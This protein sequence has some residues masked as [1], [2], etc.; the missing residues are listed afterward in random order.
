MLK[1]NERNKSSQQQDANSIFRVVTH[2]R[3]SR[4]IVGTFFFHPVGS[5]TL[6]ELHKTASQHHIESQETL[7]ESREIL[8]E[9]RELINSLC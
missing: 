6:Q 4:A 5:Q 1:N 7:K 9:S 8:Q 3:L 2:S